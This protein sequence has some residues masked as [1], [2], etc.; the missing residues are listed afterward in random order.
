MTRSK[1]RQT[2][3]LFRND[4]KQKEKKK[5]LFRNK[6]KQ[7]QTNFFVFRNEEKQKQTNMLV[8]RNDEKQ[9]QSEKSGGSAA[10]ETEEAGAV[11]TTAEESTKIRSSS[12]LV[13]FGPQRVFYAQRFTLEIRV[14]KDI[15]WNF[16]T[17]GDRKTIHVSKSRPF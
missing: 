13:Q 10:V 8:F 17:V 15:C 4:E 9:K 1:N 5:F 2:F 16:R 14:V 11:L 7:K 12:L 3:F 6:E